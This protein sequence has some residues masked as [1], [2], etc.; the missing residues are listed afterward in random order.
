MI[1]DVNDAGELARSGRLTCL[2]HDAMACTFELWLLDVERDYAES[3][4]QAAFDEID[5]LELL[6]SR[7]VPGSDVARVNVS[8][9]GTWVAVSV[10]TVRCL[11]TAE[12]ARLLSRGRFDI[13]YGSAAQPSGAAGPP[14]LVDA[15]ARSVARGWEGVRLDM[16]GVGKGF[17]LDLAAELLADWLP[18]AALLSS[19]QSTLRVALPRD[20]RASRDAAGA[21]RVPLRD[22]GDQT[23][24]V[25]MVTLRQGALSGSGRSLHGEHIVDL[26]GAGQSAE[27]SVIAAW[28]HADSAALADA[29]STALML[30][31]VEQTEA[32]SKAVPHVSGLQLRSSGRLSGFGAL[33]AEGA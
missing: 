16:G 18:A 21:W 32:L 9:P 19:G 8:P 22:P 3:A 5:R 25:R 24:V 27:Q 10:E 15:A 23:S 30:M 31:P 12:E 17:A 13:A 29:L 11:Q 26:L 20:A 7:Y 4:A 33:L 1:I 14:F 28:A 6:L 2:R